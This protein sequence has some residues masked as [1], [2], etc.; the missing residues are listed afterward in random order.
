[1][2]KQ[3]IDTTYSY[4][5]KTFVWGIRGSFNCNKETFFVQ[6]FQFDIEKI[7]KVFCKTQGH[8]RV[9]ECEFLKMVPR[10]LYIT[11]NT[12]FSFTLSQQHEKCRS[13]FSRKNGLCHISCRDKLGQKNVF[14]SSSVKS[15]VKFWCHQEPGILFFVQ[16][17]Y[18]ALL[19]FKL[20]YY[21]LSFY[22]L[23]A[24]YLVPI[25]GTAL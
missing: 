10:I 19:N 3:F 22:S 9:H 16:V 14:F 18:F 20:N 5:A 8:E 1:M 6:Y 7:K 12:F 4:R 25:I 13:V 11:K 15:E 2:C 23:T 17:P 21:F 24:E